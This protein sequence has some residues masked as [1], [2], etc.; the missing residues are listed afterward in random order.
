MQPIEAE[1]SALLLSAKLAAAINLRRP[2]FITDNEVLAT[3]ANMGDLVHSPGHW[4]LRPI[5][6]DF[7]ASATNMT[8]SI[9]KIGRDANSV[10]DTLAKKIRRT[11]APSSCLFS[12]ESWTH[13]RNYTIQRVLENFQ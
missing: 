6:T 1:A 8:H 11:A 13:S 10:A 7:I 4:S 2:I 3:T 12:C 9:F 5:L